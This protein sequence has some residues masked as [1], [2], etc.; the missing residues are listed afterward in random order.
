MSDAEGG[1]G[2]VDDADVPDDSWSVAELNAEIRAVLRSARERFPSYVV[3]E[4]TD[5]GRYGFGTFF[6]LRDVDQEAVIGCLAWSD[7]LDGV[8]HPLEDGTAVVVEAEVDFYPDDGDAQ[9]VVEDYWPLG[10]SDRTETLRSLRADL[11]AEGLLAESRKRPVPAYPDCVGLVTS[12]SG[13]A[14][15]DFASTAAERHPGATIVLC[16]ATVQGEAA[17]PSLVGAI[18]RLEHDPAVDVVV[19]TRG[20]G[21][22][23]NLWCFNEEPVVRAIANC[24]TPVVVA[25]GHEDDETLAEAVADRRAM[26]PT[27][28][29]VEATP[30]VDAVRDRLAGLEIRI[31]T[32]YGSVVD[33]RLAAYDRR[34]ESAVATLRQDATTRAADRRRAA[35]LERRITAGYRALVEDALATLERR[36]DAGLREV[37]HA[38][39]REAVT[40]RAARD[41]VDDLEAR[42]E[43]AY[44]TRVER[45]LEAVET[46]I[47][48]AHRE[49]EA[50]AQAEA[51]AAEARRLRIAV[52]ALL[53]VLALGAAAVAGLL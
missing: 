41:R 17:V 13:S 5:V 27:E 40:A 39:E 20:G 45:D 8:D 3:G 32:A 1:V 31:D 19:V 50:D 34:V 15:E 36:V 46:R 43:G 48:T 24:S 49:L 18:Q 14:R 28:A 37:E 22:D 30:D 38:A 4:V 23:A 29:G 35:S 10:A 44:R 26:T 51:S 33:D 11:E 42:I 2:G 7:T 6:D 53:A 16:G 52:V 25:V 9:L 47:E 12:P 21:S